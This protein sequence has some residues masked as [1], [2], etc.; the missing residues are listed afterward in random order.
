MGEKSWISASLLDKI[1][2]DLL[3][4]LNS[5]EIDPA[6]ALLG[7]PPSRYLINN[8]HPL[9]MTDNPYLD[10]KSDAFRF[11]SDRFS[12]QILS[13]DCDGNSLQSSGVFEKFVRRWYGMRDTPEFIVREI[14]RIVITLDRRYRHRCGELVCVRTDGIPPA[15]RQVR[16]KERDGNYV[17]LFVLNFV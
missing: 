10:P 1:S 14:E 17:C 11:G 7:T 6:N 15:M 8:T 13:E 16:G 4:H 5:H 12:S 2:A 3:D 9:M